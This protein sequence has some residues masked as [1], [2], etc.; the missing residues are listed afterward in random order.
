MTFHKP[1]LKLA[2]FYLLIIMGISLFF[3]ITVY[4][5]SVHE[6]GRGLRRPN[7]VLGRPGQGI[8][9][10]LRDEIETKQEELYEEATS[11]VLSRLFIINLIIL[12]GGGVLSYYLARRTLQPIEEAHNAL[13][14]F[15]ADASHE[16]RTPIT[17][18]RTEIEVALLDPKL[19]LGGSKQILS[20]NLEEL[21]KLGSLTEGLLR[22][23][24][25]DVQLEKHT[26]VIADAAAEAIKKVSANAKQKN[27]DIKLK[28]PLKQAVF[29]NQ[30]ALVEAL[31]IL[32]DNAIK[33]S[34]KDTVIVI[35]SAEKENFVR[36]SVIDKGQGIKATQLPYIFD[37]FYRADSSRAK[38]DSG[39][40]GIGLAIAKSIVDAH[41]GNIYAKSTVGEGSTFTIELP[42]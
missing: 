13:E 4:Q 26:V 34:P 33:Y 20:S 28:T 29:A 2:G 12:T 15:T 1:S 38:Q 27:I 10:Q 5:L 37:R 8:T 22:L 23:A 30:Q 41:G 42:K 16:L 25:S 39:G 40:Y 3:S 7:P 14:R 6:L 9:Q 21:G 17:A 31:V 19:T 36:L 32:L 18:M 11:R 24:R 35:K